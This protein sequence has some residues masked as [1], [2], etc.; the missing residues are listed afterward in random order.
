[1]RFLQ[2]VDCSY[3][4]GIFASWF[5]YHS[6]AGFSKLQGTDWREFL[7]PNLPWFLLMWGKCL[8]WLPVLIVWCCT[9]MRS[10][11]WKAVTDIEGRPVRSII[12]IGT[13][14]K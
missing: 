4:I 3:I 9:G 14:R 12:R 6:R 2:V 8:A 11:P 7:L 10:S 1:M 13:S 5:V